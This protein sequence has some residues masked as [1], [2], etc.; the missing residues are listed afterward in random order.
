MDV[1]SKAIR[2]C[3][4]TEA[5]LIQ[6]Q[7]RNK[8]SFTST[9]DTLTP[10]CINEDNMQEYFSALKFILEKSSNRL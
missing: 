6:V 4:K 9:Y 7:S 10:K 3:R 5:W 1:L 8:P 2:L